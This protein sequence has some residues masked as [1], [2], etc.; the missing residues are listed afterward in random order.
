MVKD[1]LTGP[2]EQNGD[3]SQG[4]RIA[5]E[6]WYQN[7]NALRNN[8]VDCSSESVA[9]ASGGWRGCCKGHAT[10]V[11][12]AMQ[13]GRSGPAISCASNRPDHEGRAAEFP[14]GIGYRFTFFGPRTV[15]R[16]SSS[17]NVC[18]VASQPLVLV[19][20]MS[21]SKQNLASDLSVMQR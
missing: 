18:N 8:C 6:R 3:A 2:G 20:K 15:H 7:M 13:L 4:Y 10:A 21:R 19:S 14:Y 9:S 17:V 1:A 5:T 12:S 11:L 16:D